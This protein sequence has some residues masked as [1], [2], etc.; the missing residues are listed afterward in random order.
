M[1]GIIGIVGETL[2][3]QQGAKARDLMAHRGP[4][5][6]GSFAEEEIYLGHRRLSIL[7]LTSAGAQPMSTR[8]GRYVLVYN[9]ELYNYPELRAELIRGGTQLRSRCDTEVILHLLAQRGPSQIKRFNGI[10]AL[11]FWDRK[12]RTLLLARD[13]FGIKPLYLAQSGRR[14]AFASETKALR[15]L[16]PINMTIDPRRA[17]QL[18]CFAWI[19]EPHTLTPAVRKLKP[20]H[21]LIWRDGVTQETQ[22]WDLLDEP[23]GTHQGSL[24]DLEEETRFRLDVAVQRQLLS[25]VPVFAFL[26]GG[27]DSSCIAACMAR[28][29]SQV[30]TYTI[31]P[32][33]SEFEG[34]SDDYHHAQQVAEH[35][36]VR[37]HRVE[38]SH[39]IISQIPFALHHLDDPIG[40]PAAINTWS[41]SQLARQDNRIVGL[42]GQGADELFGGYRRHLALLGTA[43][44]PH[45]QHI[46]PAIQRRWTRP[47]VFGPFTQIIRR[48]HKVLESMGDSPATRYARLSS[49]CGDPK[50]V[51]ALFSED[52]I[53]EIDGFS[54]LEAHVQAFD[55]AEGLDLLARALYTDV[56]TFMPSLNLLYTDK[57][58]MATSVEVRVPFLDLDLAKFAWSVPSKWK[59]RRLTQK[60]L[61]K[62]AAEAWIPK[63]ALYR[64]KKGFGAPVRTWMRGPL[65]E[66][67]RQMFSHQAIKHRNAFNAQRVH[68]YLDDQVAGRADYGHLLYG[69]FTLETWCRQN[70]DL[71]GTEVSP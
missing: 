46:V 71:G 44:L 31:C 55:D 15:A 18:L 50:I 10:F 22:Y 48:A 38:V 26:S 2:P 64:A 47:A 35:L 66:P 40:D 69:L 19:P 12:E 5:G 1:C 20:G 13:H 59:I 62:R 37:L 27:V 28:H 45:S 34:F 21:F 32:D 33:K 60:F 3:E 56:K 23:C 49:F 4:D 25:D 17:F 53:G 16:V 8:D 43:R 9:G 7:D 57:M 6:Q 11:A 42:S 68:Q 41:I 67:F 30:D 58:S 51:A 61:L 54:P 24:S 70:L 52:W 63:S 29:A 39:D 36:G 14:L 65:A